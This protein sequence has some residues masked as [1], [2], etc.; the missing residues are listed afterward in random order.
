M[1][2]IAY[3]WVVK[4]KTISDLHV[5]DMPLNEPTI[6]LLLLLFFLPCRTEN[7][8]GPKINTRNFQALKFLREGLNGMAR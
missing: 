3:F 1:A 7:F 4:K 6:L 2:Y 8:L 5:V